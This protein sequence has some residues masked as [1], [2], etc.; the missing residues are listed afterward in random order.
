MDEKTFRRRLVKRNKERA[1]RARKFVFGFSFESP[2]DP[3]NYGEIESD[4]VDLV[5]GIMHLCDFEDFDFDQLMGTAQMHFEAET[6]GDD[7]CYGELLE[8]DDL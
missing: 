2:P 6:T 8:R 7:L 4:I 5:C 3:V 1:E